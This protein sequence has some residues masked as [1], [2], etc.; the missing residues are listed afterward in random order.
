LVAANLV[1]SDPVVVLFE[2]LAVFAFVVLRWDEAR[3]AWAL[4]LMWAAFA[5]AFFTKGPP[6]LL[7]L[8]VIVAFV[9]WSHELG[10]LRLPYLLGDEVARRV[11][12]EQVR[13]PGR[14]ARETSRAG[15]S[16]RGEML[17]PFRSPRSGGDP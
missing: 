1:A 2:T 4:P 6:G 9:L 11:T 12:G 8:A 5:L 16:G 13:N 15:P 17:T 3:P 7:P 14:P 10:S